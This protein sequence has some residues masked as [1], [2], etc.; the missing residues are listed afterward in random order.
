MSEIVQTILTTFGVVGIVIAL[1]IIVVFFIGSRA[2]ESWLK[3]YEARFERAEN[4]LEEQFRSALTV[5][6]QIDLDLRQRRVNDYTALWKITR[7]LP[8]Y[9][10]A[11]DVTYARLKQMSETLRDWYFDGGGLFM[12]RAAK[13]SYFAL[14]QT[15]KLIL[16]QLSQDMTDIIS[17]KDYMDVRDKCSA[18]R[19]ALTQ[20]LIVT[21][22]LPED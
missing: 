15:I 21:K 2:F 6:T 7:L 16:D 10:K 17:D 3:R 9:P 13:D 11:T 18:L 22:P 8:L 20:E 1:L 5:N 12:T 19:T 14:Q 4:R